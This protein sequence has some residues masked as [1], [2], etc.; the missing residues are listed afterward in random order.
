[1]S[2]NPRETP[3][4]TTPRA[5]PWS[6]RAVILLAFAIQLGSMSERVGQGAPRAGE[7]LRLCD[8]QLLTLWLDDTPAQASLVRAGEGWTVE[9]D[10]QGC[11]AGADAA[12]APRHVGL[13]QVSSAILP[14]PPPAGC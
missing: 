7:C 11:P 2:Q 12:P 9:P 1:M 13:A 3:A 5:L 10:L 4:S 14:M 6:T 8:G